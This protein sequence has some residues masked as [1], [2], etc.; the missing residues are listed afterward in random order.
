MEKILAGPV[1]QVYPVVL[2]ELTYA[3]F[4]LRVTDNELIFPTPPLIRALKPPHSQSSFCNAVP[5]RG[6]SAYVCIRRWYNYVSVPKGQQYKEL[7]QIL[8]LS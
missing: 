3:T 4:V 6:I 2:D 7:R 5:Y 8:F 1:L